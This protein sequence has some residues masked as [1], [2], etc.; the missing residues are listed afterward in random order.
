MDGADDRR[1][2]I[3][4]TSANDLM[5]LA[6]ESGA[7]PMQIA[8]V[9]VLDGPIDVVDVRRGLADRITAV[10]RLRQR[11]E[12]SPFGCGRPIWVDDD[13]FAIERH[14]AE[15]PCPAP[16]DE[17]ALLVVAAAVA[18]RPLPRDRP[19][20]SIT[21]V[22]GLL[23]GRSALVLVIHHV[24]ADGIGGL[25][26]LAQLVDNAPAVPSPTGP[27]PAPPPTARELFVDASRSRLRALAGWPAGLGL[28]RDAAVEIRGGH[29]SHPSRCSLN[30]PTGPQRQ[31]AVA[32]ADLTSLAATAREHGA[33]VNDVLL[34]AIGG[35]LAAVLQHRGESA[36]VF[37]CSVPVSGRRD[38]NSGQL[39]NQVGAMLVEVSARG[40][41]SHS[42]VVHRLAAIAETTRAR[43]KARTRGAS[44]RL[45][46]PAFRILA[47]LG[48]YLWFVDRQ[49]LATTFVTNLHG[50]QIP[51]T[52]LGAA[53][54]D[55]IPIT[56][57]SGNVTISFAAL[58]YA[59]TLAVTVIADPEHCPDLPV[60]RGELQRQLDDLALSPSPLALSPLSPR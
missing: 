33:T 50:P 25:A 6:T 26:A 42:D 22:N 48:M 54:T 4:R 44:A 3:Q 2:P 10:R 40:D 12:R 24:V 41:G 9:L 28:L 11:L 56:G 34:T 17:T 13:S 45:L 23:A 1:R 46:G 57:L 53:V 47:R 18:T 19:L 60:V 51:M 52:F 21:V 30:Q 37:V 29:V 43:R 55:V 36:D 16:G 14:V 49:R 15:R 38:P 58:S 27:F 31:F 35:A 7:A 5:A 32:R 59:G 39:G 8:A 20:W